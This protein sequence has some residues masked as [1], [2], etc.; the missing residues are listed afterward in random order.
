MAHGLFKMQHVRKRCFLV[1]VFFFNI[2]HKSNRVGTLADLDPLVGT[3]PVKAVPKGKVSSSSAV[4]MKLE[5][6]PTTQD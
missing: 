4:E 3:M 5:S 6:P 1:L 2:S